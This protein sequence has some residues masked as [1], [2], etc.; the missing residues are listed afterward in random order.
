M[1]SAIAWLR[2]LGCRVLIYIDNNLIMVP[3]KATCIVEIAVSPFKALGFVVN[4]PKSILQPCL[5]LQF[6]GSNVNSV[7][8][9]FCVS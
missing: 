9:T 8:M 1:L 5:E 7:D 4:Y 6:L 2:Q 3:Q